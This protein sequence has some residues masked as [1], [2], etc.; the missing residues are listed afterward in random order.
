MLCHPVRLTSAVWGAPLLDVIELA[1]N[2][3]LCLGV[4]RKAYMEELISQSHET[5]VMLARVPG[6]LSVKEA[7]RLIGVSER[8]IYAYVETGKL[9]AARIGNMTVVDAVSA[10]QYQRRAPGRLR[11]RIPSWHMPP[12]NNLQYLTIITAHLRPGQGKRL[13]EKLQ[14]IRTEGRHL[15]RGTAARYIVRS[16]ACPDEVQVMLVW[17]SAIMPPEQERETA[18]AALRADLADIVA[19]ET[20]RYE[21]SQVVMHA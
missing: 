12:E 13:I 2:T 10:H 8:T 3:R 9:P 15:L 14:E 1:G 17:R 20:A 19:W 5:K 6:Y 16:R 21:E 7:A 11:T 4:G 18:L